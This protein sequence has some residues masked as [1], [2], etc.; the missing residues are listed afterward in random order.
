M[1]RVGFIGLGNMGLHQVRAFAQAAGCQIAAGVDPAPEMRARFAQEYPDAQLF[2]TPQEMLAQGQVEGV[3]IAVPTG[4]H[5]TVASTVLAAGV[6]VLLEKPMAR[7]VAQCQQIIEDAERANTLLMVAHCR[8]F[9]PHWMSWGDYVTTG[10]LGYPILWRDASA[11]PH[12]NNWFMDDEI[13]G[14][15]LIDGAIHNYDFANLIF[16]EPESAY[17]GALKMNPAVTAI[18][19]GST[20]VRYRAGHQLLISWS[21]GAR[22][23]RLAD[24]IGPQ[25]Y[26]QLDAGGLP[27]DEA[28]KATHMYCCFTSVDDEKTLIK[29]PGRFSD[30]YIHQAE[31]F[32]ACI[33]GET[34]CQSPGTEAIKAVAVAEAILRSGR[35]GSL[36]EI[37]W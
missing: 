9:D 12:A 6:P 35:E 20:I 4:Y 29:T 15:P 33:R 16:G 36:Q 32:L 19:T 37:R 7:T 25:G 2:A 31:H 11:R 3:V 26:I 34:T 28:E 5:Q 23:N 14:G 21:W 24:V 13:G 30:M 1:I 22:G 10:K 17:T 8:R 27:V 18:D